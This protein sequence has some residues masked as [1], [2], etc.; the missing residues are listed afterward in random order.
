MF[1]REEELSSSP[2]NDWTVF[3]R[4]VFQVH[5]FPILISHVLPFL[6]F[7]PVPLFVCCPVFTFLCSSSVFRLPCSKQSSLSRFLFPTSHFPLS[8]FLVIPFLFFL[9]FFPRQYSSLQSSNFDS[10][11]QKRWE[12]NANYGVVGQVHCFTRR[13]LREQLVLSSFTQICL[14]V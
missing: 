1:R 12:T 13:S 10:T 14:L 8:R 3:F 2:V 4:L 7:S 11:I 9:D 5:N 6:L